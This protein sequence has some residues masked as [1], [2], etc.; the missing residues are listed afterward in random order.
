MT[1]KEHLDY[2]RQNKDFYLG[3]AL[4]ADELDAQCNYDLTDDLF[5][6]VCDYAYD[7]YLNSQASAGDIVASILSVAD[8][9]KEQLGYY[10]ENLWEFNKEIEDRA[11]YMG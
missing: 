7:Y 3:K 8:E 9:H 4:V 1:Y 2:I 6:K 10:F 11:V 5:E